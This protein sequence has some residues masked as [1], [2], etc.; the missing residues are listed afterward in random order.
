MTTT[1][2]PYAIYGVKAPVSSSFSYSEPCPAPKISPLVG[3]ANG[4]I[5]DL[6]FF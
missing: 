4:T 6:R 1:N 5:T 2:K 3:F